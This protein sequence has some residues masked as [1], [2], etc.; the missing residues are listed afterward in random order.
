MPVAKKGKR[1][2]KSAKKKG[3]KG[4]QTIADLLKSVRQQYELKS[5]DFNSYPHSDVKKLINQY[6]DNNTLLAKVR[7]YRVWL[8]IKWFLWFMLW[9][10]FLFLFFLLLLLF[11]FICECK[12]WR[13][14]FCRKFID[15]K[16]YLHFIGLENWYCSW[17]KEFWGLGCCK[18]HKQGCYTSA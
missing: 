14:K 7:I 11:F 17:W 4:L 18:D 8:C 16:D 5:K 1:K 10:L 9:L 15:L 2:K 3:L 12:V 6:A 13:D